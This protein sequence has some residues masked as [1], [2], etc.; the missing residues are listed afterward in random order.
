MLSKE[1]SSTIFRVFGT[2]LAFGEHSNPYAN[3]Y[4]YI[5]IYKLATVVEGDINIFIYK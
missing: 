2:T 3:I 4:I 1:A 5:Y